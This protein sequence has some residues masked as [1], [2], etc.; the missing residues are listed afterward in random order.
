MQLK[1]AHAATLSLGRAVFMSISAL[2]VVTPSIVWAAPAPP[3]QFTV[4]RCTKKT[5]SGLGYTIVKPGKGAVP[6]N[7]DEVVVNYLGFF[8]TTRE[9]FDSGKKIRFGVSQVVPGFAEGLRLMRPG[10]RFTLCLPS[11]LA[12]GEQGSGG[13]IPPNTDIAFDVTLVSVV[14]SGF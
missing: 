14:R 11:A 5:A 6:K 3:K 7:E 13:A 8:P 9:S 12:Y 10:A 2:A 1:P 4:K